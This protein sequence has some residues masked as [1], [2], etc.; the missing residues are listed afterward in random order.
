MNKITLKLFNTLTKE[1][2]TVYPQNNK[3]I[4]LYTCGPTVYNYSHIGNLR[5]FVFE[6]IM[7]RA[8]EYFGFQ[9]EHVMNITDIDDKTI[10]GAIANNV[11]IKTFV[12]PYSKAFFED[13]ESLHLLKAHHYPKATDFIEK[14]IDMI[15]GLLEKGY[16]YVAKDKSI[17]F[18]INKF[19][20][21]G[22]LSHLDLHSLKKGAS[23]IAQD[24]YDKEHAS[25]FVL[26]KSYDASRDGE[27]F[28]ESPFGKGR[29]GWHIECSAMAISLL[30]KT[31]DIHAGGI[32]NIF[33]HHE[34][35]IAQSECFTG[36][37]FV[38]LWVHSEH[39]LVD[40]KKMS[41]SLGNIYTLKDLLKKGYSP[42]EVRYIL[43]QAH[44]RT[45]LNFTFKEL[46]AVRSSLQRIKDFIYRL[47]NL[48]DKNTLYPIEKLLEESHYKFK[49]SLADDLNI[50]SS[51]AVLFDLI[52]EINILCDRKELGKKEGEKILGLLRDFNRVF[53]FFPLDRK[54]EIPKEIEELA[55][56]REEARKSKNFSLADHL[57]DALEQKGY[58][59]E[60]SPIG[61]QIKK[62]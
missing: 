4:L 8:I 62:V 36:Q 44:Y 40:N 2:E 60:D 55:K 28:W 22:K 19:S 27:V 51:L 56:Q 17:Y 49:Q 29:P 47:E 20:S 57:R 58:V 25:D 35:E 26:W 37:T 30:G 12:E 48:G 53:A 38:R 46:D 32:D 18:H 43:M 45:P 7:R 61:Y 14:M 5:T 16:A 41:K 34:N 1:K 13:V 10:R 39:L 9:V 33:P 23:G 59:V 52:R 24:E 54:E 50:S 6:D 11:D 3:V 42:M 15:K 31:I 21:Y